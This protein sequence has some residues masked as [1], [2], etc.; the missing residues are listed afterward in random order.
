[1]RRSRLTRSVALLVVLLATAAPWA[2]SEAQEL[3]LRDDVIERVLDNG[4]TVLM[5]VRP[6]APLI[7]S[8]LAYRV[9][10]VNERPGI[11]GMS[12]FHEHMMFKGS[13][14]IGVKPGTLDQD[15][16][17]IGEIDA[18]MEKIVEEE[19]ISGRGQTPSRTTN[20]GASTRQLA[21][22]G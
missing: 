5:V 8:I 13:Y 7:R 10:S 4:L 19:T 16:A 21:A 6:Q 12:H 11:T 1:M 22:L 3:S 20:S 15:L 17:I 18:I 14:T 2:A 9:G